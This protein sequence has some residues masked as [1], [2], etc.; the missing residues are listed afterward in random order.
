MADQTRLDELV[1]KDD[2][3][4]VIHRVARGTDRLD[5]ELI[6]AG[7]WPDGF[8]DHNSFRG[9]PVEFADW[10]LQ[11]LPHFK[12]TH[13]FL[14]QCRIELD[15]AHDL[16]YAET[17]CDAHH[18]GHPDEQGHVTDM[19]MGLR[20]CDR[21]ERRGGEW[22]IAKRICAFDWAYWLRG[23]REWPFPADFTVGHRNRDD[24]TYTRF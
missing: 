9:G 15:L 1:A 2:I 16:A 4:T 5:H 3:T 20:Y 23:D 17:Y 21:F 6:V 8:D 19:R 24:I 14:G 18:V 12:A 13:H 22:R 11:V 10:V 7:Y